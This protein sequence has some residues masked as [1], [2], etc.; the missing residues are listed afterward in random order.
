MN[1][2]GFWG[3]YGATPTGMGPVPV[4]G[5]DGENTAT[6]TDTTNAAADDSGSNTGLILGIIGGVVVILL[7]GGFFIARGRRKTADE[8]E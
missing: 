8:R 6:G 1:Q 4:F 5:K 2:Q 3:Y 7:V